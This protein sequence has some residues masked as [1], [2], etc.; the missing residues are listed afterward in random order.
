MQAKENRWNILPFFS[1]FF[2]FQL[3]NQ[4]VLE[5]ICSLLLNFCPIIGFANLFLKLYKNNGN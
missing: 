2:K 1:R 5:I 4:P 3:Q